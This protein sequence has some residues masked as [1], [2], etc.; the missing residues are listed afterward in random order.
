[1][2][3]AGVKWIPIDEASKITNEEQMRP[4]YNKLNEKLKL[5]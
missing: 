3:T 4:V 5:Y 1:M 2:K